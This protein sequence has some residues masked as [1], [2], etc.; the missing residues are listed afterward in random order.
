VDRLV[1]IAYYP[2]MTIRRAS[3]VR[4]RQEELEHETDAMLRRSGWAHTC[5]TPGSYWLWERLLDDGR[6]ILVDRALAVS[7]QCALDFY[8]KPKPKP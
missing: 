5:S 2:D 3:H 4:E 7:I 6:T 1:R 8:G